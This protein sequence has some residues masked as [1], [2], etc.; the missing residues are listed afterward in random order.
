MG[1]KRQKR[2]LELAF[3]AQPKGEAQRRARKRV[4]TTRAKDQPEH[5]AST[6]NQLM[7]EVCQRQNMMK[8]FTQVKRNKGS[9]GVDGITT[10]DLLE[11]IKEQWSEIRKQLLE[12]SYQPQPVRRVEIPKPNGGLRRLGIPTTT[13]RLIQQSMLQVLQKDWD[14]TFSES[15]YGFRPGRSGHQAI[16]KAQE[17]IHK[18]YR[19]AVDFDLEKFFDRV[20]HDVLMGRVAHRVKDKRVL[21]VIRRFL[22]AGMMEGG[23]ASQRTR[24]MPQGGPLSPLLSNLL[25]DDLDRELERR[26]HRFCRYADD[27]NVYVRSQRAGERVMES[28][29]AFLEKKLKLRV[30]KEKSAVAPVWERT[31]LGFRFSEHEKPIRLVAKK[32]IKRF[33]TR[34]RELTRRTR[35]RSLEQVI[36]ETSQYLKGWRSYYGN[37]QDKLLFRSL[38]GWIRRKVRCLAWKQWKTGKKRFKELRKRGVSVKLAAE[39]A[40]TRRGPWRT[41]SHPGLQKA[42][43]NKHLLSLG[44]VSLEVAG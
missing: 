10:D 42:L 12:G 33:K 28:I 30:N 19:Y 7:E 6:G 23:L 39:S 4:E 31:F 29:T 40:A 25:L 20:N 16:G 14:Q 37:S 17:Y 36:K 21:K 18:G 34:I 22:E 38:D 43:S 26:G 1:G 3:S 8:A 2:Q 5:S 15:S 27:C 24:G 9:P 41:S 11:H 13:D 32:A 44:L 35:G